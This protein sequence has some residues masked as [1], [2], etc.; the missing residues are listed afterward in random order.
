MGL[1]GMESG[2]EGNLVR[3]NSLETEPKTSEK[4]PAAQMG[5]GIDPKAIRMAERQSM[6]KYSSKQIATALSSSILIK[7]AR[8]QNL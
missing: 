2:T 8:L 3:Q 5:L 7:I 6:P 4:P 1:K